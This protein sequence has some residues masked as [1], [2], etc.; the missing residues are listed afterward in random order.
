MRAAAAS[1]ETT[2]LAD[3]DDTPLRSVSIAV[4]VLDCFATE[5]QLGATQV[6][7][8]IGVAK[9]T[10]SRMLAALAAGGLL[11]RSRGGRYRLGLKL[12]E[13]GQIAVNRLTL[14]EVALP[15][16]CELRDSLRETVQLGIPVGSDVL[17]VDR[18]EIVNEGSRFHNGYYRRTS[19]HSSS[20]GRVMA[21]FN[22]VLA[23]AVLEGGLPR[24]TPFTIVDPERYQQ[25]LRQAR[26]QG[27]V[28]SR[29]EVE[30]GFSSLAAPVLVE[31]G[32]S[33]MAIAAVS[34]VG[35]T[36][37]VLGPRKEMVLASVRRGAA[38]ISKALVHAIGV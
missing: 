18:M 9:S 11:E 15:V 34:V 28:T 30:P 17:Y 13:Y 5:P 4:R 1:D 10:A 23:R 2:H 7:R 19:A 6:A 14:R 16:L 35:P 26:T 33:R 22:P 12:F 27:W 31:R 3:H 24:Y 29:E 36:H 8:E 37:R 21:A 38:K 20:A 25:L 32:G